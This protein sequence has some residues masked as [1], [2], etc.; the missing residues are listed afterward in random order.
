MVGTL[1]E[2]EVKMEEKRTM[3]QDLKDCAAKAAQTIFGTFAI[4]AF[5][6]SILLK[7]GFRFFSWMFRYG[8]SSMLNQQ[9]LVVK[10]RPPVTENR[11]R[12]PAMAYLNFLWSNIK[13]ELSMLI[14]SRKKSAIR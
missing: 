12:A 13:Y 1:L 9:T 3:Q 11:W 7:I 8:F 5:L 2:L 14:L 4:A 10:F 6:S